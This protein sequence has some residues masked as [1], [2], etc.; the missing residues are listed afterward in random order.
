MV[1]REYIPAIRALIAKDLME[2]YHYTQVAASKK[3]GLTQSAMSRYLTDQRGENFLLTVEVSEMA[4]D[5][6]KSIHE[7]L[8]TPE[9]LQKKICQLCYAYQKE[10]LGHC[11]SQRKLVM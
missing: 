10:Q 3:L 9:G 5:I 8:M 1:T 2:K 11:A 4:E 6:A 7:N